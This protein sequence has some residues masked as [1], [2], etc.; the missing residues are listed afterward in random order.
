MRYTKSL[1][2]ILLLFSSLLI[3]TPQ[4]C[5]QQDYTPR[6]LSLYVYADGVVDVE[7]EL[8]IALTQARMN[9][10]LFGQTHENLFIQDQDGLLLDYS[11]NAGVAT[12]DVLGSSSIL[13]TYST[14]DLTDKTGPIWTLSL[15]APVDV[16]VNIPEDAI[17]ISLR[18]TPLAISII[19]NTVS[20]TMPA[21]MLEVSYS[22]RLAGTRDHARALIN[23]AGA[24]I[25][26]IAAEGV[27]VEEAQALLQQAKDAYDAGQYVQ[28]EQYATQAKRSATDAKSLAHDAQASIDDAETA[29]DSARDAGR[30]SLL[31]EAQGKLDE[32]RQA[33]GLFDYEGA[34]TLAGQAADSAQ[35]SKSTVWT[36]NPQILGLVVAVI[37]LTAVIIFLKRGPETV[38]RAELNGESLEIDLASLFDQHPNLRLD[39]KEVIRYIAGIGS[40][41]FASE[42]RSRFDIPKSSA[43]RMI[44][45]LEEEGVIETRKV[46][47]ETL[48]QIS[49]RYW[50]DNRDG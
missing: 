39:E 6:D 4:I 37:A 30:T 1:G 47:R 40:G 15:D 3:Y 41:V 31:E 34:K 20:L 19:G 42:L 18:P 44:R 33:Y 23:D 50:A 2:I 28:A 7:Y 5:A 8:D 48:V 43:W 45:R 49:R 21:G 25:G 35:Q 14:P 27:R 12:I 13:V 29:I 32:A 26:D 24:T 46:G 9:L 17:V 11:I 10:T 38:K 36:L 16:G 22:L